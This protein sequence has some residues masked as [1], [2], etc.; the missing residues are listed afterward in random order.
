MGKPFDVF[1]AGAWADLAQHTYRLNADFQVPGKLFLCP[2][3]SLNGAEV[4]LNRVPAGKGI[5]FF[6]KHKKN[7]EL[8]IFVGGRGEMQIDDERFPVKEGTVVRV[9]PSAAR[10]WRNNSDA[11]L[12]YLCIQ[13]PEGAT[14][15]E[16]ADGELVQ[17]PLPW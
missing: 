14:V 15:S 6:H 3:L 16:T 5:P 12:Y 7:E 2:K 13:Y 11:D 8:Y 9:S 17:R 1:E 4:S 10:V